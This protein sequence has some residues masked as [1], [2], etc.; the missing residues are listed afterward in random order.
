MSF[1]LVCV[2][3]FFDLVLSD[4]AIIVLRESVMI[5]VFFLQFA[6]IIADCSALY[7]EFCG[8]CFLFIVLYGNTTAYP[9]LSS[10]FD[11]SVYA[12]TCSLYFSSNNLVVSA[13][14]LRLLDPRSSISV[15]GGL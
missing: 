11:P 9:T 2:L 10:F 4:T 8:S 13:W 12:L 15:Y 5:T 7:I 14:N 3:G 1:R 6:F